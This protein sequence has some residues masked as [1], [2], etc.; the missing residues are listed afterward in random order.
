MAATAHRNLEAQSLRHFHSINDISDASASCNQGWA[1]IDQS[2]V[3]L[4]SFLVAR[5]SRNKKLTGES[6]SEFGNGIGDS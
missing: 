1:L 4:P 2:I 5:V 3:D 6:R